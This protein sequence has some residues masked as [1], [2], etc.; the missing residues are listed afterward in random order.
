MQLFSII[1]RAYPSLLPGSDIV[2][3]KVFAKD[4]DGELQRTA[5]RIEAHMSYQLLEEDEAWEDNMDRVLITQPII[6]CAFKNRTTIQF[7]DTTY[8]KI[9]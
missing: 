6:G 3:C 2:K 7:K 5:D 1:T 9:F 4:P 8:L